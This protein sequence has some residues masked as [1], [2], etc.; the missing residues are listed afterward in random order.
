MK[1]SR[2]LWPGRVRFCCF[3]AVSAFALAGLAGAGCPGTTPPPPEE[4]ITDVDMRNMA[5]SP[6]QVTIQVG[7]RV[8]WTNYDFAPHTAT[9]GNPGDTDAGSVFDTGNMTRGQS[10][11]IQFDT[12]GQ[13]VY[14]CEYHP[15]TMFGATVTVT[16]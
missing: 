2:T 3:L 12:A 15:T 16:E 9:S 11:T 13:F 10:V 14:F 6:S 1:W 5:F 8:R 7:E 4:G